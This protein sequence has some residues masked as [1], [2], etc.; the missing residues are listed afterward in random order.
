V[1][2]RIRSIELT[3]TQFSRDES[4]NIDEY[5][6]GSMS[7]LRGD[8]SV[9]HSVRLRFT[10]AAVR[11]VR[12]RLWH[13]HQQT[14]STKDGAL[15]VGFEVSHLREAERLVLTWA[16]ECE[17]LDPPEL[18]TSVAQ[19]LKKAAEMHGG[20]GTSKDQRNDSD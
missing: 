18:R 19:A 10:G 6:A 12:E 9:R 8:G 4:F 16:P 17:A 20:G 13:P 14:E 11:Y 3:D 5:L 2:G 15:I 1:P 7:V